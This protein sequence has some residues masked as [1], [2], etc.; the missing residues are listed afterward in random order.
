MKEDYIILITN[1]LRECHDVELLD[2]ILQLLRK[3]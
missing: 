1:L 2:L 3:G